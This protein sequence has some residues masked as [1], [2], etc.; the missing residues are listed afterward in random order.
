MKLD[1][2]LLF[3]RAWETYKTKIRHN[4]PANFGRELSN[5][6]KIAKLIG[7]ENYKPI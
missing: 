4:C 6:Y 5:C 7:Y 3:K 1:K 2:S